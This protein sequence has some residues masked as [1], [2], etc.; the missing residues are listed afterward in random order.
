MPYELEMLSL[1]FGFLLGGGSVPP[2]NPGATPSLE[3]PW[4]LRAAISE[5]STQ[6]VGCKAVVCVPLDASVFTDALVISLLKMCLSD[7]LKTGYVRRCIPSHCQRQEF[8]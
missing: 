5:D 3:E 1:P 4:R 7:F 6:E 2:L 8:H